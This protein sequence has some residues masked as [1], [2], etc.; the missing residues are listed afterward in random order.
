MTQNNASTIHEGGSKIIRIGCDYSCC[1]GGVVADADGAKSINVAVKS[2]TTEAIEATNR[3]ANFVVIGSTSK[4]WL[5]DCMSFGSPYD[6]ISDAGVIY[7]TET[8]Q[9]ESMVNDGNIS[10]IS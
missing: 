3:N 9:R 4:M 10:R 1:R 6:I 7:T 8:Y 5:Y 2:S